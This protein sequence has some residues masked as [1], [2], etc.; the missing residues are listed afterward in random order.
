MGVG[1]VLAEAGDRAVDQ[2]RID[3]VQRRVVGK[4]WPESLEFQIYEGAVGDFILMGLK[5]P[6]N[7]TIEGEMRAASA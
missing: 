7:V 6:V 1:A 2:P 3:R 4:D 5:N